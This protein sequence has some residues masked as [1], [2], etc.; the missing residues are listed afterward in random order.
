M[1]ETGFYTITT[2]SII[3][4]H[5]F[6]YENNFNIFNPKMN[7]ISVDDDAGCDY[8]FQ[9]TTRL[10]INNTYVLIVTTY[11]E[12]VGGTFSLVASGPNNVSFS[13]IGEY[14]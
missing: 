1:R 5:G 10:E 2:N 11:D 14:L 3:D 7:L 12:N 13:P 6:I 9:I 4:T 8:Q